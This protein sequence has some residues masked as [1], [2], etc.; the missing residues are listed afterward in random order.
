[1]NAALSFIDYLPPDTLAWITDNAADRVVSERSALV[2][3]GNRPGDVYLVMSGAFDVKV[4]GADGDMHTV[5]TLGPGA[6][7]GEMS[8]LDGGPASATIEA[9]EA[10]K[11][12]A[13][14]G[15]LLDSKVASDPEFGA[16]FYRALAREAFVRLRAGNALLSSRS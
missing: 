12:L 10:S 2:S 11:V 13:I 15:M 8:W 9:V 14:R 5:S 3:E 1:M 6:I 7:V 4:A 16:A